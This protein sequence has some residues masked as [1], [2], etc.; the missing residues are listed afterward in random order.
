[1]NLEILSLEE[2]LKHK[3]K[4]NSYGI[5]IFSSNK[6]SCVY[7]MQELKQKDNWIE[8]NK[9]E[10]DY[11]WPKNWKEFNGLD[12]NEFYFTGEFN[13]TYE[14][15]KKVFPKITWEN[16]VGYYESK[17]QPLVRHVLF[18]E[19]LALKILKD[20]E[21]VKDNVQNVI[22]HCWDG[23]NR[24]PAI[25]IAMNEIYGWGFNNLKKEFPFYH[26]FAYQKMIEVAKKR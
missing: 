12:K 9:Y 19:G 20:Y 22:I 25:G 14:E 16:L 1:M 21:N 17:G 4:E 3:P 13:G 8:I 7:S 24:A 15:I 23:F 10:F 5:R 18:D 26:K 11:A 6:E 2:A